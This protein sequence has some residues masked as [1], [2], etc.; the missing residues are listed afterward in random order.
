MNTEQKEQTWE[1]KRFGFSK[2]ELQG[3][4]S[5]LHLQATVLF[6][7][8][9][10]SVHPIG[11]ENVGV[12]GA[13]VVSVAAKNDLFPVGAEHGKSIE[14]PVVANF[15]HSRSIRFQDVHVERE[16]AFVSMVAAKKLRCHRA[17]NWVPSWL[18][19]AK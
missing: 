4:S 18:V 9:H 17:K 2:P 10:F 15:F 16:A 7:N 5:R 1:S 3:S 11:H 12:T 14:A 19:Q 6:N 8:D 13:A